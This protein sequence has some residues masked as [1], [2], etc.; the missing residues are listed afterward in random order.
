MTVEARVAQALEAAGIDG[1][2]LVAASG[3]VDSTVLLH[4][5]VAL[6]V[7]IVAA[8]VDHGLRP[9]S[10]EDGAFVA[11][12]AS[13]LGVRCV[14]L[15]VAVDEG[16]VQAEAR[17]AR[18]AALAEAAREQG[19]T[20]VATGHTATDQAETVLLALARG[21]GLRGLAG[22][23]P[24]R[25]LGDGVILLRPLLHAARAEV[26]A[27]A[28]EHGWA[29]RDDSSN[30]TDRFAR[31]RLRHTALPALRAEGGGGVDRRIAASADAARAALETVREQ[32]L[33]LTVGEGRLDLDVHA[34]PDGTRDAVL[35]EAVAEWAPDAARSRV[36]VARLA[37]LLSADVGTSVD[38]GGLIVWRERDALRFDTDRPRAGGALVSTALDAPPTA[39]SADRW[40]VVVDADEVAGASVR[41]WRPGDRLEPLGLDGSRPVADVLREGGVARADRP[42]APL[43]V[44]GGRVAWVVGHRLASW[45]AVTAK[46]RRAARW[47]WHADGEAG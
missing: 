31:N 9:D 41:T 5:L 8:H 36:L 39:F 38:S 34:L 32:L 30:A 23:P 40:S 45:A 18:Y 2:A 42:H 10:A 28:R 33:A 17:R 16:N 1:R 26:E 35:A 43:V 21:A 4:T 6:G 3:G 20:A 14:R 15:A 19:C 44:A 25:A 29:W 22:M 13:S 12:L 47:S 46:T 24:T 27:A 37:A 7:E 11:D